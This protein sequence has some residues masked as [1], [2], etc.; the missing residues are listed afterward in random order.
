MTQQDDV[1]PSAPKWLQLTLDFWKS[2][3]TQE[4]VLTKMRM[5]N[6]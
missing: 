6:Q 3:K 4:P 2:D 1:F 5:A